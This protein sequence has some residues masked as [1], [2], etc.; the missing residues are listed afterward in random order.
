MAQMWRCENVSCFNDPGTLLIKE[1][2][3]LNNQFEYP[4]P[5]TSIKFPNLLI[6]KLLSYSHLKTDLLN[7][8]SRRWYRSL[9][10]IF[11]LFLPTV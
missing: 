5:Q 1:S 6:I 11:S 3:G 2:S 9:S 7:I 8:S 4:S 10:D